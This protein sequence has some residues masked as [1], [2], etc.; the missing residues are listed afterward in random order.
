MSAAVKPLADET[1]RQSE[2]NGLFPS[3]L[4]RMQKQQRI[5]LLHDEEPTDYLGLITLSYEAGIPESWNSWKH[6]R[7]PV[8][9]ARTS[10][11]VVI[12]FSRM[13]LGGYDSQGYIQEKVAVCGCE[14]WGMGLDSIFKN[15]H[16]CV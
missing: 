2:G 8:T 12:T 5:K 1:V 15:M 6:P 7:L 9:D 11:S 4:F 13:L 14:L 3:P 10:A 16:V